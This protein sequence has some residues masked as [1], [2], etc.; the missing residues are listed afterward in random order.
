[1]DYSRPLRR[2]R[3]SAGSGKTR[4][5]TRCFLHLLAHSSPRVTGYNPARP[6]R[7][8]WPEILAITFTNRAATEMK[9]RLITSLKRMALGLEQDLPKPWTSRLAARWLD[10]ILCHYGLLNI[11]T[12]DSLLFHITRLS[13]LDL[14]LNPDFE[15]IFATDEALMP[16]LDT[17]LE[18]SRHDPA[19]RRDLIEA[20]EDILLHTRQQGFL[21]GKD[22]RRQVLDLAPAMR[23]RDKLVPARHLRERL[24]A[25]CSEVS[26]GAERMRDV[27]LAE[28]LPASRNF[29]AALE[30][31]AQADPLSPPVS[32]I[33]LNHPDG[34]D[35]ALNKAGQGQGSARAQAAYAA[36]SASCV[37]AQADGA[38]LRGALALAPYAG[39]A[40]QTALAL[41]DYLPLQSA[42]PAEF[43]PNLAA[44]ALSGNFGVSEALCRM[45]T[46]LS[47]IL[48]DEFQDTSRAQWAALFPLAAES[49]ARGGSFTYVGDV[50]Q[51][52]YGWRGGDSSLF[53]EAA[54]Y[55]SIKDIAPDLDDE[56]L[57]CNWRSRSA[58]V[59]ANNSI[60]S[61][62]GEP[63]FARNALRAA[64]GSK[65][66][67]TVVDSAAQRLAAA[68][69]GAEQQ[70]AADRRGGFVQVETLR[71]DSSAALD[72]L[73]MDSLVGQISEIS[74]RRALGDIAV[75][76][77]TNPQAARVAGRL[78]EAKIAVIT[79]NSL[80]I[81]AHPIIAQL[82][83]FLE[84][85]Q[86]P[87][88]DVALWTAVS[89]RRL[90]LPTLELAPDQLEDWLT[91]RKR[92]L[93]LYAALR[94]AH[95]QDPDSVPGRIWSE[96]L[97]PF[98][99][100]RAGLLSPYDIV[101]ELLDR[102]RVYERFARDA[103]F[104]DRFLEIIYTAQSTQNSSLS[105]FL[106]Y[107]RAGGQTEKAP[108][109]EN[110]DAVR[111]MTI[112]KA[113]GLQFPVT[114]VPWSAFTLKARKTA[115]EFELCPSG[116]PKSGPRRVIAAVRAEMGDA[117][118]AELAAE[119]LE[120]F[121]LLYV[122]WT[123]ARDELYAYINETPFSLRSPGLGKALAALLDNLPPPW[124]QAG[125]LAR[126]G[127]AAPED[128]LAPCLGLAPGAPDLDLGQPPVASATELAGGA[129]WRPMHWLPR[130][131]IFRNQLPQP[132]EEL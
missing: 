121:N 43:I 123:R 111:V 37:R 108:M 68:F 53:D 97:L 28:K 102:H 20:C 89:G 116:D 95:R 52:I 125:D 50:K 34:L 18:Q 69:A 103:P 110:V 93:P 58:I 81:A 51:A 66:S 67:E 38:I 65:A 122:A 4:A 76:T 84:F 112:H 49:L 45:G 60:F 130:L 57:P 96:A 82:V 9:E 72:D 63:D 124:E 79:E 70:E 1:M 100:G 132:P 120:M 10:V 80:L 113:K 7:H 40:R 19:S 29:L 2:I 118:Y 62:L 91:R 85:L 31:C 115:G 126:L 13:A 86:S 88:N 23:G 131:K 27:L 21:A 56:T 33:Y 114:I 30:K 16:L 22:L 128:R 8:A 101:R 11:R 106:E 12:I 83:S 109:P 35:G 107:F 127:E 25:I 47:H 92:G 61:R 129:N 15:P 75:L 42:L 54:S 6:A 26:L 117:Y 17:V 41:P 90:F 32:S 105:A 59:R 99:P 119:A 39:L 74:A 14:G 64:L 78:M 87:A 44:T 3:A 36:L 94:E 24:E 46:S 48:I 77:R 98:F 5:L 104:L 55:A 73:V 71:A